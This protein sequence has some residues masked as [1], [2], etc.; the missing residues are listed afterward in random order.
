MGKY[1]RYEPD[2]DHPEYTESHQLKRDLVQI[3]IANELAEANRYTR[4][5]L[6][7][8]QELEVKDEA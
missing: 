7:L 1:D 5:E 2:E 6:E 3:A 4:T 8:K